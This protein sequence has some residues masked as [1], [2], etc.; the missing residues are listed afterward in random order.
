MK[1]MTLKYKDL[2][3]DNFIRNCSSTTYKLFRFQ[4]YFL[5]VTFFPL[6]LLPM[7]QTKTLD[8]TV[9][10][11]LGGM[12]NFSRH[13]CIYRYL[14]FIFTYSQTELISCNIQIKFSI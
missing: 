1:K 6:D 4:D 11:P 2:H 14:K 7:N 9:S 8:L 5:F 10:E 13:K 12:V 3:Y